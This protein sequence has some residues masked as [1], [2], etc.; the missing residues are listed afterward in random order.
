MSET[1][2]TIRPAQHGEA[3]R[4]KV[5]PNDYAAVQYEFYIP[6]SVFSHSATR[7]FLERI[8]SVENG[9]TVFSGL[10]GTWQDKATGREETEPVAIYRV[11]IHGQRFQQERARIAI[12]N[13]ADRL[14]A[15]LSEWQESRQTEFWFTETNIHVNSL[16]LQ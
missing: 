12:Q 4:V 13:E 5:T 1:D 11:I 15:L 16:R 9:A 2:H 10:T 8:Q 6:C 3:E 14:L 7:L